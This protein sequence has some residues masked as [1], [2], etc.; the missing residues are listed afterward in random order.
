MRHRRLGLFAS[1]LIDRYDLFPKVLNSIFACYVQKFFDRHKIEN[2]MQCTMRSLLQLNQHRI[3]KP[4]QN[5]PVGSKLAAG[6]YMLPVFSL[7]DGHRLQKARIVQTIRQRISIQ[8]TG[9]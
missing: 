4:I 3:G 6:T 5:A 7:S 1:A 8:C 9:Q 2:A